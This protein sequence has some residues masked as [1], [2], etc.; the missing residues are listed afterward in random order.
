LAERSEAQ[1]RSAS[2]SVKVASATRRPGGDHLGAK[3]RG[4]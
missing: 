3:R 4:K 2:R 1:V